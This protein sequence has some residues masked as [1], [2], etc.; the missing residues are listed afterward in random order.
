M[1]LL[2]KPHP[3]AGDGT[4]LDV[5]PESAGWG[6]VGFRAVR[7]V[8]GQ[9]H[10]GGEPGREACLVLLSGTADVCAGALHCAGIG[11]R[12]GVFVDA[13]PSAVYVPAGAP[14]TVPAISAGELSVCTS[15]GTRE[16]ARWGKRVAVC[17]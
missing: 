2:V 6:H 4:L 10:A 9:T 16:S 3:P 13:P 17:V 5:T 15:P 14:F 1:N 11:G 8:A 7:L 12:A